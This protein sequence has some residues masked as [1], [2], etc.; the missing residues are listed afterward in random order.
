MATQRYNARTTNDTYFKFDS[1]MSRG[2]A[3]PLLRLDATSAG[4]T[5]RPST[6]YNNSATSNVFYMGGFRNLFAM[7]AVTLSGATTMDIKIQFSDASA[8]TFRES[9]RRSTTAGVSRAVEDFD[10]FTA[11]GNYTVPFEDI[12][13]P[14][15]R[16]RAR[17]GGGSVGALGIVL[18]PWGQ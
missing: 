2:A 9:T 5:L 7:Y 8:G 14:F 1:G 11:N 16:F 17:T 15:V 10:R 12:G 3:V 4:A 18:I 13:S 6:G